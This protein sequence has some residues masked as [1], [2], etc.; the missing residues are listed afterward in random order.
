M[1]PLQEETL[2][3][4]RPLP[5]CWFVVEQYMILWSSES[6]WALS[7]PAVLMGTPELGWTAPS[8]V[9]SRGGMLRG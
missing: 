5:P 6:L 8:P 9:G 3:K 1:P 7:G 4:R 2:Y